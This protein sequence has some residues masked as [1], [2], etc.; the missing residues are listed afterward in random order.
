MG[1]GPDKGN[2]YFRVPAEFA[3]AFSPSVYDAGTGQVHFRNVRWFTNL[4]GGRTNK[5]RLSL[6]GNY[7]FGHEDKYPTYDNYGAINVDK[8]ADIPID[9]FGEMGV[10][11]TFLDS[12]APGSGGFEITGRDFE[13]AGPVTERERERSGASA[14][15]LHQ[16]AKTLQSNPHT[17]FRLIGELKHGKDGPWDKAEPRIDRKVKYMR[18]LIRHSE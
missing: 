11:I 1:V 2:S 12:W 4:R 9:Y 5:N 16:R 8:V 3:D 6:E 13:Q 7:Y 10:P 18:L 14:A 17:T 15:L